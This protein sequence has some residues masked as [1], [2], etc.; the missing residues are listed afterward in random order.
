MDF[1]RLGSPAPTAGKGKY[2]SMHA[3]DMHRGVI[4]QKAHFWVMQS[5]PSVV[6]PYPGAVFRR[7]ITALSVKSPLAVV[8]D[9]AVLQESTHAAHTSGSRVGQTWMHSDRSIHG[10]SKGAT[11]PNLGQSS[12][13]PGPLGSPHLAKLLQYIPMV[14]VI[15]LLTSGASSSRLFHM[16]LSSAAWH[17]PCAWHSQLSSPSSWFNS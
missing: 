12:S 9:Q 10:Q 15:P 11:V 5:C 4:S 17:T 2:G 16:N 8:G 3:V 13:S 7:S 14:F 1:Y 6:M